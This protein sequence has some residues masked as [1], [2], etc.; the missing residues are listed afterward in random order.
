MKSKLLLFLIIMLAAMAMG[1][2][3]ESGEETFLVE[4]G[5][6]QY[7][8]MDLLEYDILDMTIDTGNTPINIYVVDSQNFNRYDSGRDFYTEFMRE[9]TIRTQLSFEAPYDG[10]YYVIFES[11]SSDAYVDVSYEI[12]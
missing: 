10:T 8:E 6:Y 9:G 3:Y 4:N 5:Y 2:T 11:I 12:Y 7:Y 1:C